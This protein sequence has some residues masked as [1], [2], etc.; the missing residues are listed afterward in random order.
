[1]SILIFIAIFAIGWFISGLVACFLS[2]IADKMGG[3]YSEAPVESMM[4]LGPVFI[5]VT[6]GVLLI[7]LM[8]RLKLFSVIEK[9]GKKAVKLGQ[10]NGLKKN[11][12]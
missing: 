2:G 8:E 10:G 11:G 6:F 7:L 3:V 12:N 1:M 5:I 4:L 9:M